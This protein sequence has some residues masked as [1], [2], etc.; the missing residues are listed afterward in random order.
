MVRVPALPASRR[1]AAALALVVLASVMYFIKKE[2]HLP[3]LYYPLLVVVAATG[4]L[5]I[6]IVGRAPAVGKFAGSVADSKKLPACLLPIAAV[7]YLF[8]FTYLSMSR[9]EAFATRMY[10]F[11]NMDQAIWNASQGHGLENTS[12]VFPFENRT[13]LANHVELIYFALGMAYR[14]LPYPFL[15]FFLQTACV[16]GGMIVLYFITLHHIGSRW[17]SLAVALMFS[18]YPTVQLM[19]LFDFHADVLA[20][21]WLL[22]AY[23]A[24]VK[25]RRILF[26]ASVAAALACKEYAGLAV[27]G[28]G[29]GLLLCRKNVRTSL[30][31]IVAG[32]GYFIAAILVVNPCFNSGR[33]SAILGELYTDIGGNGGVEGIIAFTLSH[34][35]VV[36]T[37]L[38]CNA[39]GEGIF[40]L[41]FPLAFVPLLVP[42]LAAAVVPVVLKDLFT[43]IDVGVHRLACALPML[44][45]SFIVGMDKMET[46]RKKHAVLIEPGTVW[47]F[48]VVTTLTAAWA[49]G[50][51]PLGHRFWS[52]QYKYVKSPRVEVYKEFLSKVPDAV[53]VSV[54]DC[55][56]P[57]LSHRRYCYVFPQ[58]FSPLSEAARRVNA[59]LIDTLAWGVP[60]YNGNAVAFVKEQGFDLVSERESIFLFTR[61]ESEK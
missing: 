41:L 19:S 6:E 51:S 29:L 36:A 22:A 48:A 9:H 38:F 59:V 57:H 4:T 14:F 27:G 26:W 18:W 2:F 16:A 31:L 43:G 21:P 45:V 24:Y 12:Q 53:P 11:G 49:Y 5:L 52:E 17:K 25:N 54:T 61:R 34:P 20:V 42:L 1:M 10:D 32:F 46:R 7:L 50:P 58:P 23:L 8:L 28:M 3:A 33:E 56:A 30:L 47:I 35:A 55:F 15:L 40:Y 60:R 37:R 44:F 39:N 13:R